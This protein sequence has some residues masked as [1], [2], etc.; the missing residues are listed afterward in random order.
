MRCPNC[1]STN[2]YPSATR[3]F[4]C[5]DCSTPFWIQE[6][7]IQTAKLMD[8]YGTPK[9]H[10]TI[11]N[12]A[13]QDKFNKEY[14]NKCFDIGS[15]NARTLDDVKSILMKYLGVFGYTLGGERPGDIRESLADENIFTDNLNFEYSLEKGIAEVLKWK[16]E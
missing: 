16:S 1:N 2:I 3:G 15:G 11:E 12:L 5:F 6:D 9:A 4:N 10:Q 14:Y 8:S 13:Y 7:D